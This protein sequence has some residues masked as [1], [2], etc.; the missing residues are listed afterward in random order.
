MYRRKS[1]W[2]KEIRKAKKVK[3]SGALS[4]KAGPGRKKR[5]KAKKNST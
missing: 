3:S 5:S 1:L 4:E 2:E